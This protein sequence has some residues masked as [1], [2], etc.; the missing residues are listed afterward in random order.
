M[1]IVNSGKRCYFNLLGAL[2]ALPMV[3]MSLDSDPIN[4]AAHVEPAS[5]T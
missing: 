3:S 2:E 4:S 5:S 1:Y